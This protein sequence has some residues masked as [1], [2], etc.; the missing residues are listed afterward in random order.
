ME[1]IDVPVVRAHP[2]VGTAIVINESLKLLDE[3]GSPTEVSG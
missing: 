3:T 1:V 2:M